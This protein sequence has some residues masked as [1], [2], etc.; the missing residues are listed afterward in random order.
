M[1]T[2]PPDSLSRQMRWRYACKKFDSERV[3]AADVWS[4]LEDALVMTPSSFGLQPWKFLVITSP[5]VKQQL[6]PISWGQSQV[7]DASH[8]V[9]FAIRRSVGADDVD[10]YVR[11]ISEVRGV[12]VESLGGFRG[13]MLNF[14]ANPAV[15]LDDWAARQVYIALGTFMTAAAALGVDTCPLEGI[16]PAKYDELLQLPQSGHMTIVACA[17]GYRAADDKHAALPK[18]RFPAEEMIARI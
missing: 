1:Q 13:V 6:V 16:Q 4:A 12:P 17:A 15:N 18:V 11:R 7:R 8:V 2:L 14:L 3:I 5:D 10:R 9:V